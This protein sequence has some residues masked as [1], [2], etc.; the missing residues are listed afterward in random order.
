MQPDAG[1]VRR[2]DQLKVVLFDQTRA[3]LDQNQ[4]LK[5][6][7]APGT[8]SVSFRGEQVHVSSWA[9]RFLFRKEQLDMAVRDLSGGEQSRIFIARLMLQ[10]ADV[11]ILDEPTNDLDIPSLEVLEETLADF[12]R[13]GRAGDAR[14]LPARPAVDRAARPRR[15]AAGPRSTPTATSTSGPRPPPHT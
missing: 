14:P 10:P 8:H 2:A 15:A 5:D 11:L 7:L 9:Q 1:T 4:T 13:G 12:P 6:A 3:A